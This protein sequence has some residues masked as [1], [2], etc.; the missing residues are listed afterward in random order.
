MRLTR[1]EE[2]KYIAMLESIYGDFM[3]YAAA[4]HVRLSQMERQRGIETRAGYD[5]GQPRHPAGSA[6][7][8]QWRDAG[9]VVI[10]CCPNE[11]LHVLGME[12]LTAEVC[13]R[14]RI[15]TRLQGSQ[16]GL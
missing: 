14:I 9:V 12:R 11:S 4:T 2:Q 6:V 3:D 13:L 16:D 1:E 8:G 5:P 15:L 7:V 10:Q